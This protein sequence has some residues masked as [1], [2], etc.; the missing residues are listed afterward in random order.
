LDAL[1]LALAR[2]IGTDI[3][4]TADR[5]VAAGAESLGLAVARFG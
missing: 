4:A 5:V 1:H 2:R 3:V